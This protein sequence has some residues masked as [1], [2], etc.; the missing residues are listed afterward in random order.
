MRPKETKLKNYLPQISIFQL[1]SVFLVHSF[2][3]TGCKQAESENPTLFTKRDSSS[4]GISFSNQLKESVSFNILSYLYY[5]N[6]GGVAL[7]DVNNDGLLDIYF[8]A[9]EASNKLYLNQG[10]LQFKDVTQDAGVEGQ[11]A[12]TTGVSMADVNGDGWIDIHVSQLGDFEGMKGSNQLYINQQDGTF[13]DRA[14]EYGLDFSGFSTQAAFFDYDADGDLDMYLLTHSVHKN[15]TYRDT[16]IR[17]EFHPTAGDRFFEHLSL[18]D[19]GAHPVFVDKT[20]EVGI[21]SS[22]LGY[23]L[24]IG[25]AD[26]DNNGCPDI[27]IGN[28]F[29]ENDYLYLNNC[30]GTFTE[31]LEQVIGHTSNFTMG[32]DISDINQDGWM[33]IV[34]LDMKPWRQKILKTSEPPNSYE[35][36]QFKLRQGYAYQYPRN[37]VQVNLGVDTERNLHFSERAQLLG[38]DATDWSW[39]ALW[40][41]FDLNG[42]EDLYITNG[43]FRRPNDME[44]INFISESDVVQALNKELTEESLSFVAKMPQ[45][46]VPNRLY[47]QVGSMTFEEKGV[48]WGLAETLF[49]N[50]ASYG[51]LDNDGDL[52]LVVNN[53]NENASIYENLASADSTRNYISIQ[54]HGAGKNTSGIGAKVSIHHKHRLWKKEVFTTRGFQSSVS[55]ILSFGLGE[56]DHVDSLVVFW[57]NGTQTV[58][59]DLSTDQL[60][61]VRQETSSK[62]F[63]QDIEPYYPVEER[64]EGM[65]LDFIHKENAYIDFNKEGLIPHMLSQEGPCLAVGDANGDGLTDIFLGGAKYQASYLYLQDAKGQFFP[66]KQLAFQEDS[67]SEDVDALFFD[68]DGDQDLD[69]YVVSGGNEYNGPFKPLL[70]R[71][72]INNGEGTFTREEEYLPLMY[73]NGACVTNAD[74]DLD[75]DQDLF[76]GGR[77]VAGFYGVIPR[78]YILENQ[79]NGKFVDRTKEEY[80]A[81]EYPGLITDAEWADVKGDSFPDLLLAGEWMP[82]R[83][84]EN[85]QGALKEVTDDVGLEWTNGWWNSLHVE[86]FDGDG[87]LDILGG[88][89]GKNSPFKTSQESP[90]SLYLKDFDKNGSIDP[91]FCYASGGK[92][93]PVAFRDELLGQMVGLKK[94]FPNYISYA[95]ADI[96]QILSGYN[97]E[98]AEIRKLYTFSSAYF[99]NQG[100]GNFKMIELPDEAQVA[101]IYDFETLDIDSD[102][103]VEIFW[104]GNREGVGPFQ[105]RYDASFGGMG[106]ISG[107]SLQVFPAMETGLWVS[108]EVR[109]IECVPLANGSIL[110]IFAKNNGPVQVYLLPLD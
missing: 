40:A 102:G 78:S 92:S 72:Y 44:Y 91:I 51:D 60:L 34:S 1:L 32:V 103:K 29:H 106:R 43:I 22:R 17:K 59:R 104:A 7:G 90:C 108:G 46:P 66:S 24:G 26:L 6:G 95:E 2:L 20:Q 21:Y 14:P 101:P 39:S 96:S 99:D 110:G 27:Y 9:N 41:D 64:K 13:L 38:M 73:V 10:N 105:G 75:G 93:F 81:L 63:T 97:L 79:G 86:D 3:W 58:Q 30:D 25:L 80:P 11:Q 28:D 37:A 18:E 89:L 109:D 74:M 77:S 33:D 57:P 5:Y 84:F 50:G 88:N 87:D 19:K 36:Y 35:I 4:T 15:D 42:K 69:L 12:W 56:V 53:L 76:I 83:A 65:G 23:G 62:G 55:P 71:L 107:D 31:S 52:D 47:S 82:I 49:S 16:S 68:A 94:K 85:S 98:G 67:L 70:D 8:S 48:E 61:L 54:L 45:V 100:N